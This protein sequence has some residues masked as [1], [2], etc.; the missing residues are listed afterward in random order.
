M[1]DQARATELAG[2]KARCP[3][4]GEKGLAEHDVKVLCGRVGAA[5]LPCSAC[6][7]TGKVYVFEDAVRVECPCTK[8][9]GGAYTAICR[10]CDGR[11]WIGSL[12]FGVWVKAI[13]T[14]PEVIQV[15]FAGETVIATHSKIHRAKGVD[16]AA[17]LEAATG[18]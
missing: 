17:L 18:H 9:M 15:C 13:V 1:F 11:G 16:L 10:K 5:N 14:L 3:E 2:V 8:E 12:D 7:G 6:K 4:C